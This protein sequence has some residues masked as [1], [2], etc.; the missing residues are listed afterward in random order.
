M[1]VISMGLLNSAVPK[2]IEPPNFGNVNQNLRLIHNGPGSNIH[3]EGIINHIIF[4]I[5]VIG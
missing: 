3:D 2:S 5:I 1:I 4:F